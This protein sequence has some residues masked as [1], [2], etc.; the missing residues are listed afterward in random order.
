MTLKAVTGPNGEARVT[1][2][3]VTGSL[4]RHILAM[5]GAGAIGLVAIFVGDLANILFLSW[6]DDEAVVAAI[7]YASSILFFT[8]SIGIGLSIAATALVSPRVGA[9]DRPAARRL[10]GSALLL[11]LL[12]SIVL[13]ALVWL[14]VPPLL[15]LL[16]ATGRTHALAESYL[17]I[18]VP[19]LPPLAVAMTATALLRSIGDARRAM[20]VTLIGAVVNVALDPLL[21]FGAG[22]GV[23]GAA[24]ASGL[25]RLF[26]VSYGLYATIRSHDMV[27]RPSAEEAL[28]DFRALGSVA[29][30]AV[31]T[32]VA[33]PVGNAYVTAA[34]AVHGDSAVAAW[35]I[36]GRI[37]PVAF[38]AIYSLSGAIG[39]IVGQNWGAGEEAR[40]RRAF[41]LTLGVTG[42]F[43]L[44]AWIALLA[45]EGPI[46][47]LFR[48]EG[49][50]ADLIGFYCR[51]VSPL[52][53]FLGFLFVANAVFNT[54]GRARLSTALNWG[55]A[56][57]GTVPFVEAGS[58]LGGAE[59][60]L[61]G[62]MIGAVGFGLVAVW[63][64]Y[65]LMEAPGRDSRLN[66]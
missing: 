66:R 28:D 5:T 26:M 12:S 27:S 8:T 7:G 13:A 19:F 65:R 11:T 62:N 17:Q 54:L 36:I 51:D 46:T 14:L 16:G 41:T 15:G 34:I 25:A 58:R 29:V 37:V 49:A 33:T 10:A 31:L 21:I 57:V 56:T 50:V 6:L 20:N 48:A 35:A 40:M 61:A 22:L 42:A 24:I 30:P 43:T 47:K 52:F 9:G 59:G 23:H 3:F 32:N 45:L 38:G 64:C 4:L 63:L 44:A 55:R 39:P 60:V 1:P 53:V 18:L 2:H